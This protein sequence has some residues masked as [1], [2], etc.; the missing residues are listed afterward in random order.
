MSYCSFWIATNHTDAVAMPAS[1]RRFTVLRNGRPVTPEEAIEIDAWMRDPA[2]IGAL[3]RHLEARQLAGFNMFVPLVTAGKAEMAELALSEVEDILRDMAADDE[4]GL[5]FTR[6]HLMAHVASN[7]SVNSGKW[8]GEFEGAWHRY[9]VKAP[10]VSEGQYRRVRSQGTQRKLFCFRSRAKQV[11]GM[12][13]AAARREAS[14]WGQVD[15]VTRLPGLAVVPGL[16]EKD[17]D[18]Q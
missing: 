4:R 2:S 3:V 12:P 7:F 9:C 14:K 10:P 13:E 8:H 6:A 15:G 17:E 1:D 5:V 11:V 16:T 18:D